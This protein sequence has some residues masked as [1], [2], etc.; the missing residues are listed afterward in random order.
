M[1]KMPQI[2]WP[3]KE[4]PIGLGTTTANDYRPIQQVVGTAKEI[5]LCLLILIFPLAITTA[6]IPLQPSEKPLQTR[7]SKNTMLWDDALNAEGKDILL[8]IAPTRKRLLLVLSR[9]KKV[10]I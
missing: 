8:A 6:W 3:L 10:T 5:A 7:K 1:N 4:S 2:D 9:F